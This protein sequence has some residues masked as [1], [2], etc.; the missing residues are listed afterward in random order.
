MLHVVKI[1][2]ISRTDKTV[3]VP[4]RRNT[5]S[6]DKHIQLS[7]KMSTRRSNPR[8]VLEGQ[9]D[10]QEHIVSSTVDIPRQTVTKPRTSNIRLDCIGL[11]YPLPITS[12]YPL[13]PF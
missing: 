8:R 1:I 2:Q 12:T 4:Y 7:H 6:A 5:K 9:G 3:V 10:V 11:F 13:I